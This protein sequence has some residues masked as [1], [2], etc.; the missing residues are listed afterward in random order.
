MKF[1]QVVSWCETEH[2]VEV[3]KHAEQLGF[4]GIILAEHIYYPKQTQS[5]YFYSPDGRSPQNADMEFPDPLISFAAIASQTTRLK[6]MTGIYVLP[7]RHPIEAAKNM[8][9]LAKLS[10]N[11]FMLGFG[12]GWLKE[13]F[14]QFGIEFSKRGSR[15]DEMLEV[16]TQLWSGQPLTFAGEHFSMQDIQIRPYPSKAIP[17]IGGGHSKAAIKRAVEKCDGWY[18]PGNTVDELKDIVPALKRARTEAKRPLEGYE[19]IAPLSE[20]LTADKCEILQQLGVSATV[21]Y[22]FLFGIGPDSSLDEKKDYMSKFAES[23]IKK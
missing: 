3:A 12:A 14:D 21:S 15:M 8:A 5:H 20:E 1:W 10:S 16:M 17:L 13:E 2:L 19:I 6:M 23:F 11:R 18:G 22:P 4:E 7:L 9:T